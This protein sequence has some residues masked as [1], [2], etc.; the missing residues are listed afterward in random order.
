MRPEMLSVAILAAF[1]LALPVHGDVLTLET[2]K[3]SYDRGDK[4]VFSGIEEDGKK[5]VTLII[6]D[7]SGTKVDLRGDPSSDNDGSFEI[8]PISVR[9]AFYTPGIYKIQAFTDTQSVAD[10]TDIHMEYDGKTVKTVKVYDLEL[11]HIGDRVID[12][13][14]EFSFVAGITDSSIVDEEY[15]L[16]GSAPVGTA[17]EPKSGRFTWTPAESQGPGA[18]VMDVIVRAGVSEDSETITITVNE[19]VEPVMENPA[20]SPMEKPASSP[21]TPSDPDR[22][23]VEPPLGMASFVD[24][25]RDPQHY[26]D[27]YNNEGIY[28]DWFDE[29]FPQYSSI[30]QA[31]GLEEP[32]GMASFVDPQRDPQHYVDRYNNEGI[33]RDWFDE[34]FPQYSSIY[35]AVGLEEP[36]TG[37]CGEGTALVG[38]VCTVMESHGQAQDQM[39]FLFWC[40]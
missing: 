8:S 35:Q 26:V 11:Q 37:I 3:P 33:Y 38:G 16:G 18:Y 40:W 12:E 22:A 32:L 1:M 10:S 20:P 19:V 14:E 9:D 28:R 29:R 25:Q 7:P 13:N 2:D 15:S 31:V 23:H 5:L 4:I 21:A 27:R 6:R 39:C 34:R 24:P 30:Y 36:K 17:I